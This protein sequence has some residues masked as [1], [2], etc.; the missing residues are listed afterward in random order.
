MRRTVPE[1]AVARLGACLLRLLESQLVIQSLKVCAVI[2]TFDFSSLQFKIIYV[3][4][5]GL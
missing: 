1:R 2:S 3:R 5:P 4:W